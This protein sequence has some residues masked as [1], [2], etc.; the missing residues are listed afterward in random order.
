[1]ARRD[2]LNSPN[3]ATQ[4]SKKAREKATPGTVRVH[5][6]IAMTGEQVV[7]DPKLS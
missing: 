6:D 5:L 2:L 3:V 7:D 4:Q 1:L